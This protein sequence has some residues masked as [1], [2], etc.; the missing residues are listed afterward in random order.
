MEAAKETKFS[1]EAQKYTVVS[2]HK[3][4]RQS[5]QHN[6][7]FGL[8]QPKSLVSSL[9][10]EDDAQNLNTYIVRRKCATPHSTMKIIAA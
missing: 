5:I 6:Q 2:P 1:T 7:T 4:S 3:N 9:G 10:N 8:S